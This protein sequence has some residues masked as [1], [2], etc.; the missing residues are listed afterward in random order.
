VHRIVIALDV[1]VGSAALQS[2]KDGGVDE[3]DDGAD[4]LGLAGELFDGNVFVGV[5]VAGDDIEGEPFAGFVEDALRLL[6][7]LQQIG[8]LRK[9]GYA[10]KDARP[11]QVRD[12]IED[13]QAGRVAH[14]DDQHL[15]LL[16]DGH[17]VVAEHQFHRD[18]AQQLVLD[19]EVLEIDELRAVT[20]RKSF[21][22]SAFI[23]GGRRSKYVRIGHGLNLHLC[24]RPGPARRWAGKAR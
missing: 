1:D 17:E 8:D 2:G 6:G 21:G 4:V 3:A 16:F 22:L 7:L 11:E 10:D 9:S 20:R 18:G 24:R 5:V 12:L 13:H 14:S 15:A 19:L 23:C